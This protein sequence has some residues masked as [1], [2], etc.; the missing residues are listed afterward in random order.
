LPLSLRRT[1]LP[2]DLLQR[3]LQNSGAEKVHLS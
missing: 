2:G 1:G 3:H